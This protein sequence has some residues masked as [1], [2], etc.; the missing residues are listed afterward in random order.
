MKSNG[1]KRIENTSSEKVGDR[2][3]NF[4]ALFQCIVTKSTISTALTN[5]GLMNGMHIKGKNV[6]DETIRRTIAYDDLRYKQTAIPVI[7]DGKMYPSITQASI[8]INGTHFG[9]L[10]A[11]KRDGKYKTHT[12]DLYVEREDSYE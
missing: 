2:L 8:A 11:L 10:T 6:S 9:L 12:V 3:P 1:L 5:Q 4:L 7:I